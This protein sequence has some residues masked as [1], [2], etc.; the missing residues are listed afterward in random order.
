MPL[1]LRCHTRRPTPLIGHHL[2]RST[3]AILAV[4][5]VDEPYFRAWKMEAPDSSPRE[6]LESLL[7]FERLF[8]VVIS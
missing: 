2:G 7:S 3:S 1:H 6:N 5:L 4:T 8:F